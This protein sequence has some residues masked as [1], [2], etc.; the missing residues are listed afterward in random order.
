MELSK[1]GLLFRKLQGPGSFGRVQLIVPKNLVDVVLG[2]MHD[3]VMAGHMGIRRTL[4][5]TC[6]C[7]CWYKQRES[8][9][10]WCK[11]YTRWA[12]RKTGVAQKKRAALRKCVTG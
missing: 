12:A 3:S 4:A 9:M 11:G 2:M 10:L 5:C 7:F 8:V 6:L 1:D